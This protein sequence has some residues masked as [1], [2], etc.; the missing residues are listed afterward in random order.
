MFCGAGFESTKRSA[1]ELSL[2][3]GGQEYTTRPRLT[4]VLCRS[5][6][7]LYTGE[8]L[9]VD[10]RVVAKPIKPHGAGL[11]SL[12]AHLSAIDAVVDAE[13][14]RGDVVGKVGATGRVTGPHLHWA[15]RA[16]GARVDPLSVLHALGDRRG[17]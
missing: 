8:G 10:R 12:F 1:S 17:R 11:V 16:S 5:L 13:V 7:R 15:M 3:D 14:A 6:S 9:L 2:L 4:S